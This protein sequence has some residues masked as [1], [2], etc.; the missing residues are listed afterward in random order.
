L[1]VSTR[2]LFAAHESTDRNQHAL[3]ALTLAPHS[4]KSQSR[5][6]SSN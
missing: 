3:D 5:Q 4:I 1:M 6:P 2:A